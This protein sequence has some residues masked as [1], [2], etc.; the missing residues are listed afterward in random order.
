M[1]RGRNGPSLAYLEE[2]KRLLLRYILSPGQRVTGV[3]VIALDFQESMLPHHARV[4]DA[5]VP[6]EKRLA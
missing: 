3:V 6:Q 4:G 1:L 5:L 2:I